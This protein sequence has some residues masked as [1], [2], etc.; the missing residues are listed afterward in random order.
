MSIELVELKFQISIASN[1]GT[2]FASICFSFN[3]FNDVNPINGFRPSIE[4][5]VDLIDVFGTIFNRPFP[6]L[7]IFSNSPGTSSVTIQ[8][9]IC[10]I[11]VFGVVFS[12]NEINRFNKSK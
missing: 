11:I 4:I 1:N 6:I 10:G 7:R 2:P 8:S 9:V 3:F 12:N 5:E